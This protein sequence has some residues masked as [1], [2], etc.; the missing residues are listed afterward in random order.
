MVRWVGGVCDGM[1]DRSFVRKV[2]FPLVASHSEL[3]RVV[4][5]AF[6]GQLR[7]VDG[8]YDPTPSRVRHPRP[9]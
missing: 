6:L 8:P 5:Q 2:D 7:Q 4:R 3:R 9:K 1:P